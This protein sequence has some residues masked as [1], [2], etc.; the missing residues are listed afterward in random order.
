MASWKGG[1]RK[2]ARLEA[3]YFHN[4]IDKNTIKR[5]KPSPDARIRILQETLHETNSQVAALQ[6]QV[7]IWRIM[8]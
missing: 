4:D 6:Y 5:T 3:K 8:Y 1:S 2:K 7:S